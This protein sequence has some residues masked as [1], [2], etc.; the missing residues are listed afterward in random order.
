MTTAGNPAVTLC[1]NPDTVIRTRIC[2]AI[3]TPK[4][5]ARMCTCRHA[6]RAVYNL[7]IGAVAAEGGTL[8]A[9]HKNPDAKQDNPQ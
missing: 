1:E 3:V 2:R 6:Q 7:G 9:L 8:P 5:I 4:L